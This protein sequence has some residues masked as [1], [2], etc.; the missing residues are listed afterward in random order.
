MEKDGRRSSSILTGGK[1][2]DVVSC[3]Q[4]LGGIACKKPGDGAFI[5][6]L[7]PLVIKENGL[8]T[9]KKILII[10]EILHGRFDNVG[11]IIVEGGNK[12]VIDILHKV[13]SIPKN[14]DMKL[15]IEDSS[16]L[17][18]QQTTWKVLSSLKH[19]DPIENMNN[20]QALPISLSHLHVE[21]GGDRCPTSRASLGRRARSGSSLPSVAGSFQRRE[22][23]RIHFPILPPS[24]AP[25][26]SPPYETKKK[27]AAFSVS[28]LRFLSTFLL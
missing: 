18:K 5:H 26:S 1:V 4:D 7:G 12:N 20:N 11:G 14:M 24:S 25:T 6:P 21:H 17:N 15:D 23:S 13:H 10:V 2:D 8:E 27:E 22:A 19:F 28:Y 3:D 16:F 9:A